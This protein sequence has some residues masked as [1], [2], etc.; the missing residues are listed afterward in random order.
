VAKK[1]AVV[2]FGMLFV[3]GVTAIDTRVCA[4]TVR[5]VVAVAFP[6]AALIVVAPTPTVVATPA[7]LAMFEIVATAELELDQV[8]ALVRSCVDLSLN[9]PVAAN[10][11]ARPFGIAGA[12]GVIASDL[13][14]ADPTVRRAFAVSPV[15]V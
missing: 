6:K 13:S 15:A 14:D 5:L 2:P 10:A 4:V 12:T 9:V 8:T 7:L 11:T 3:A 1:E